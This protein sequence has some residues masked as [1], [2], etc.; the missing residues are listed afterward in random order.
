MLSCK[1]IHIN[2]DISIHIIVAN[3]HNTVIIFI[4]TIVDICMLVLL[5]VMNGRVYFYYLIVIVIFCIVVV[6]MA[7]YVQTRQFLCTTLSLSFNLLLSLDRHI[8]LLHLY[9]ILYLPLLLALQNNP[10][11]KLL[12]PLII[13]HACVDLNLY[14]T[15]LFYFGASGGGGL[16]GEYGGVDTDRSCLRV[17]SIVVL[18]GVVYI[19][20]IWQLAGIY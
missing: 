8:L 9:F 14:L 16:G 11:A 19:R 6:W 18:R 5:L 1:A 13:L 15:F 20:E 4:I 2:I 17:F 12:L 10:I 3:I 7:V